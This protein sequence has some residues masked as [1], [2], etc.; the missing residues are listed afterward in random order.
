[1]RGGGRPISTT[2]RADLTQ[3]RPSYWLERRRGADGRRSKYAEP[4]PRARSSQYVADRIARSP[5][6]KG[7]F[8]WAVDGGGGNLFAEGLG[9]NGVIGNGRLPCSN[10]NANCRMAFCSASMLTQPC[11]A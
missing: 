10:S 6:S 9:W 2:G 5:N 11:G 1:M 3:G 7:C 4:K 8:Q